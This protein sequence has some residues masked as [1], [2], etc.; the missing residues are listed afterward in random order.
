MMLLNPSADNSMGENWSSST[1]QY[2]AGDYGTPGENN[3][4]NDD[5]QDN[6]GDINE[7][8]GWNVLDIVALANCILAS[9]CEITG[10][11]GDLNNDGGYNIL[12]LVALTNCILSVIAM[13]N[14]RL[15][16]VFI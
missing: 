14:P 12:D 2:G 7:D 13:I 11:N 15:P 1:I 8:G 3:F 10:C 16:I 9:N 4:S 5:C 6:D